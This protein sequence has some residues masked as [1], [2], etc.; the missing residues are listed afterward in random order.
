MSAAGPT[1]DLIGQMLA[2]R[3]KV[4][5][6]RQQAKTDGPDPA[7]IHRLARAIRKRGRT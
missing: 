2:L 4:F 5:E 1:V 6:W 3:R 7:T